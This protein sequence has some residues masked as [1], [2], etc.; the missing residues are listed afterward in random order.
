MVGPSKLSPR[1]AGTSKTS[2][3]KEVAAPTTTTVTAPPA[4]PKPDS[5]FDG[6][7][8]K[9]ASLTGTA[10]YK[11]VV[12][13]KPGAPDESANVKALRSAAAV[14]GPA[15]A[16]ASKGDP[17]VNDA[18]GRLN[19]KNPVT[20]K[21]LIAENAK[22]DPKQQHDLMMALPDKTRLSLDAEMKKLWPEQR[23]EQLTWMGDKN[24]PTGKGGYVTVTVAPTVT[25]QTGKDSV[26]LQYASK[27]DLGNGKSVTAKQGPGEHITV[28]YGNTTLHAEKVVGGWKFYE[29]VKGMATNGDHFVDGKAWRELSSATK[30]Q[31]TAI[32][33]FREG[34]V[35]AQNFSGRL[36]PATEQVF[37]DRAIEAAIPGARKQLETLSADAAKWTE[38][39]ASSATWLAANQKWLAPAVQGGHVA[40]KQ[41]PDG[42]VSLSLN[43]AP[44][45]RDSEWKKL[46]DEFG[47][48]VA[49]FGAR[50]SKDQQWFATE[51]SIR[52]RAASGALETF[53]GPSFQ[54]Y[55]STL[56]PRE[57]LDE[58]TRLAQALKG[59]GAGVSLA[60][61][62]FGADAFK[63]VN[64]KLEPASDLAKTVFAGA[65]TPEAREAMQQLALSLGPQLNLSGS[66]TLARTVEVLRGEPLTAKQR[67]GVDALHNVTTPKEFKALVDPDPKSPPSV[68]DKAGDVSDLL[69]ELGG[70]SAADKLGSS[71]NRIAKAG[72]SAFDGPRGTALT[73]GS[74]FVA[75][76]QVFNST[77][78]LIQKG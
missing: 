20:A 23:G 42:S 34:A 31:M 40:M 75:T 39:A 19:A 41:N 67:A 73:A 4:K 57:R 11:A 74:A 9:G 29:P 10:A 49:E 44:G 38:F 2:V 43:R 60:Q 61:D 8:K 71:T 7:K 45:M 33:A 77:K 17:K 27:I 3:A 18:L 35:M 15:G 16:T 78:D 54:K 56:P 30:D 48:K 13:A 1:P 21:D 25:V 72:A 51:L 66:D 6:V 70:A 63:V 55:L 5:N 22:L 32:T 52:D 68:L 28:K 65:R 37:R 64:G 53:R 62:L 69:A 46:Q 47:P 36:D 26:K 76:F 59:S 24:L 50:L 58:V 12:R 14:N